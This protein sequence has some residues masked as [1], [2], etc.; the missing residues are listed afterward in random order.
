MEDELRQSSRYMNALCVYPRIRF[1]IQRE[2]EKV[3]LLIREHP[4]TQIPWVLQSVGMLLILFLLNL[5]IP[6]IFNVWQVLFFNLFSLAAIAAFIWLNY[7][8]WNYHVGLITNERILDI[9]FKSALYKEVSIAKLSNV[10]EISSASAGYAGTLFN[11]GDISV[12]T[13]GA[14]V[15]IEF[16]HAPDPSF[17][18]KL[19]NRLS[20]D[21]NG[22][23]N[24]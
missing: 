3:I 4:V 2:N 5:I 16:R 15:N 8:R 7:L 10:E 9:D 23:N 12:M 22:N 13:A 19:I 17:I 1:D 6:D 24:N 21:K 14:D 11:Y 18:V 20:H